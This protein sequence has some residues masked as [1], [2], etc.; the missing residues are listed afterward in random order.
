MT[1]VISLNENFCCDLVIFFSDISNDLLGQCQT[2]PNQSIE[3]SIVGL[4]LVRI[5]HSLH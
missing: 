3:D 5:E 2:K 1:K 4:E